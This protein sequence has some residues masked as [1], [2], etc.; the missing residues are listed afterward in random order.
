MI[1]EIHGII[2]DKCNKGRQRL[3]LSVHM[4]LFVSDMVKLLWKMEKDES[5]CVSCFEELGKYEEKHK[6]A[7]CMPCSHM[8]HEHCITTWLQNGHSCP[9]C[10]YDLLAT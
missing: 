5:D 8:F 7:M 4:I 10:R 1:E 3:D 2:G 6:Q 9:V